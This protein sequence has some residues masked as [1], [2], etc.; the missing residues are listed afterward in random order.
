MAT[1]NAPEFDL[2]PL[3]WVHGEIDQALTRGVEALANY[4]ASPR[5]E[6]SLKQARA[7]VHQ[8]AGAIQMVGLDAVTAY[9]DELERQL[10]RL[11]ELAPPEAQASCDLID[12]ACRKLK[13]F[14]D[15]LVGG[16]TPIPLKL[17]PE[18]ELMQ[19]ARGVKAAAPTDLFYP[20]LS[21]RA[22]KLAS[23]HAVT[24]QKLP[25]F[26]VKQRR[27]FQRGLLAWLRG[28]EEGA[29]VMRDAI[30]SIE[31]VQVHSSQRSFWWAVGALLESIVENGV[32][33]GFGVKQLCGR[34]DLQIRRFVEGSGKV[35]DRM[36]R[37]VLYYVAISAPVGP[38]V[39]AVQ[40]AYRLQGLIPT[41]EVLSADVVR[42]QPHV[43][44]ARDLLTNAKDLWLKLTG[45]RIESLPKLKQTLSALRDKTAAIGEPSLSKLASALAT[46]LD[47]MP[48]GPVPEGLAMEYATGLLLAES[49]VENFATV[50]P[51]F[52]KQVDA[53]IARL[54]VSRPATG[55]APP[56]LDEMARRAQERLLL[57]QVAREIQANLRHMEQVLDAFFR[58]HEKRADLAT[59]GHDSKQITGALR[60]LGLDHA[61]QLLAL[62]QQQID[63][64]A[65]PET[66]V[67][68]E[69]LEL[70]AEALSG[71][72]FYIEAV[73][74]QRPDR[75]R[76]IEPLLAK[77]LGTP[78]KMRVDDQDT[79]EAAVA[80]LKA[81][82]PATLAALQRA[83]DE[84]SVRERLAQE[85]TTLKSDAELIGDAALE[86]DA[87]NA[88]GL[89]ARASA[90]DTAALEEAIQAIAE[91]RAAQPAPAPSEE[92]MRLLETDASQLD[93]ELLDIYLTEADEVLDSIGASAARLKSQADDREALT[94][95]RRGFHTLKGSGRMVG[96]TDLGEIAYE[97][98]KVH[99]RLLEEERVAT[100]PVVDLIDTA[101]TSFRVW[102]D[103]L[104]RKGRV[105]PDAKALRVAIANVDA[106]LPPQTQPA[107]PLSAA[108]A[109][110]PVAPPRLVAEPA[111]VVVPSIEVIELD[112]TEP[113][114][115]ST[116]AGTLH[117]AAPVG[118][119]IEFVPEPPRAP[120]VATA[121]P[122]SEPEEVTI[123]EVTLSNAL[124]RILC[125]EAQ[126][127]LATLDAEMEALQFDPAAVPSQTMVRASHTL[128]GIHRTGGFPLVAAAAKAL[129]QCLLG[130]EQRGAPLPSGAQPVLARAVASLH[131]LT[132]RVR[133][134]DPFNAADEAEAA[135]VAAEL[136]SLR[137]EAM[138]EATVEDSESA[139]QR[140]ATAEDEAQAISARA[141][142]E[143][144]PAMEPEARVVP[145]APSA[146]RP[147]APAAAAPAPPVA[148]VESMPAAPA[149]AM[150]PLA[151]VHDDVDEQV[152]P[153]FL[154]EAAELFPQAGEQ[155]RAWRRT[156]AN[157]EPAQALRRT[158]HTFKG[159]ARMAGAMRLGELTHLMESRLLL[160]DTLIKPTPDLFEA[161]DTDLDHL[162][163][164]LDRLQKS[165]FNSPLPWIEA[166]PA[167][168]APTP[169]SAVATEAAP[170]TEAA[171]AAPAEGEAAQRAM[172]RVR[173]DMIDRLVNE[174]GE[175]AIARA[176]VEGELRSLKGNLLE[177]TSSVI[178]LRSQ[179]REIEI[180]AESQIQSQLKPGEQ[181]FDPLEF[182]RFTHFQELTRS[183]AEGVNDVSTVQ[184][185]LLR[186]IDDADAALLAQARL[187]RDV[188][189]QLFSIRT[190]PFGSLSE[191]LYRILR[192][193]AKELDKRANLELKGTQVELDR[194][195]LEK[196]VGPLEHLLRNALDH[197]IEGRAE[198]VQA[199]KPETGEISLDVHQQGNEIA[200]DLA[201]DGA[202][203][204]FARIRDKARALGLI[205]TETEP[206]E[207]RLVECIFEPGFSTAAKITQISGRGVGMDVVRSDIAALGGRVEVATTR[208]KGSTFT[209]YLP[210]T[211]AVAQTVLVRAGGRLW[212]LPAPMV[213]QVQQI[214]DKDLIDLY[215][216]REVLWQNRK[217]PF[218]YLPRLLGN[219]GYNPETLRYNSVVLLKSGQ[220]VTA[221]HVDEMLGNQEVVVKNIGPQLARVSGISG[222]TVLGN[223]EVV[224]IINPVQ[225]AQRVDESAD[226]PMVVKTP[227]AARA[228]AAAVAAAGPPV[229]MVVDDSLTVRKITS[230]L[231]TREGY[232]VITAKDGLDALQ[233]L[234]EQTPDAMLLDI[235]MPRMDG[236]ELA[237][238]MKADPKVAH[239]PII[240]ITSRTAEKHR[241][242]A[243]QL[244]IEVYLGKPYQ[245]EELLKHLREAIAVSTA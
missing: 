73:E 153:I 12:R 209:L 200:I 236:F 27:V 77:R 156:P 84:P 197:G 130:L 47:K 245:E 131:A 201:D 158:L 228:A 23:A 98:E 15:E 13:I 185:S 238:T 120:A 105:K 97:V 215:L 137:Q 10:G 86:A 17:F 9:T 55:A 175:V 224:L 162:A 203:L 30:Q 99:N 66:A 113:H 233:I 29:R 172:L 191:R 225:L 53:M 40:R 166:E 24:P 188:Q 7:H 11:E 54:D 240:M 33:S 208:G 212:A 44:E 139:A 149:P 65:K 34:V 74:Q 219:A 167:A 38:Q 213:E 124:Y 119:V 50:S 143:P 168:A 25:S 230:R 14:L 93:Q 171:A 64:Y 154:E 52:P 67:A 116:G 227:Q 83:P 150:N 118:E 223:G 72:G 207:A 94:T 189:Q 220:N 199:G 163:F 63:E 187:S 211:L 112:E 100:A 2:G 21:P 217:Y 56:M 194:S 193:T 142:A 19:Q 106:A 234:G 6:A 18:Y 80:D 58:D 138:P 32:E 243:K 36:R 244:G 3:T 88:L 31:D 144:A 181:E 202:G 134:R 235:E 226:T 125:D 22:P 8:A 104:R 70:L 205:G 214:K 121:P 128:C 173:A 178:R 221:V 152:L 241:A 151:N 39:Q 129:E 69:D 146:E 51:E 85:L 96:L 242:R 68:N 37:E 222:A 57:A 35:A 198:R 165:E 140:A 108:A 75:E 111:P 89:L 190:V 82:L 109:A 43:R 46:R 1:D 232:Q 20:D 59:L 183:L 101:L 115:E 132:A 61:E 157:A 90:G 145:I 135:E 179:V 176:R 102:V 161:L 78:A 16:A 110:E 216:K 210:L 62:C 45:G 174:A 5:D 170:A 48:S 141:D 231:L 76:L 229:V 180:Q 107:T 195:V 206:T 79:V 60:I 147:A 91:G 123:G 169:L 103:T 81:A 184:Q 71:L 177:L 87:D 164:V 239:I 117:A 192:Q 41:A 133:S 148:R 237:K 196:L 26:M 122:P 114:A 126:Q 127:H 182:D 136:E 186:N 92:T 204:D 218:F 160:G 155:L 28:D 42:V 159:S 4:K 49:A 95:S